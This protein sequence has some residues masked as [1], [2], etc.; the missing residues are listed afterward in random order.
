MSPGKAAKAAQPEQEVETWTWTVRVADG[1]TVAYGD[2]V[3][4]A[5]DVFEAPIAA[6]EQAVNRGLLERKGA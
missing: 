4:E 2:R 5:A 6:V 1:N 3:Y